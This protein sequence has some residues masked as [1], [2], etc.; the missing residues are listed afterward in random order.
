MVLVV[1][2]TPS[3]RPTGLVCVSFLG[4]ASNG[5]SGWGSRVL[6]GGSSPL[7]LRGLSRHTSIH[8]HH[9]LFARYCSHRE[10]MLRG[11]GHPEGITHVT[12]RL[13]PR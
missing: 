2:S 13:G 11:G 8:T 1:P 9:L 3:S 6:G 4:G 12:G 5:L 7:L 10:A